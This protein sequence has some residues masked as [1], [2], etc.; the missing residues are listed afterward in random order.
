MSGGL[1]STEG[2]DF[3]QTLDLSRIKPYGD[4]MNDGKVQLS[5]T[6]PVP[7]GDE[8]IEAAKQLIKKMG[9]QNPQVV[10]FRELT[11]GFTFFNCYGSCE[12]TV[13]YSSIY[14]PKVESTKWD[15]AETDDFIRENIGRKIVVVGASTGTDA[16]TVGIDAIM[17]M[18]GFAG[19]YGLERYEMIEAYNLGSQVP[20][21]EFIAKGIELKADAL[22][23]SQTVTQKD[24]HIKNLIELVE[25]MEAEGLRDKMILACGGPRI[26][27]ELA[28][29]LGYDAGFGANTYADDVASFIAQ[30]FHKRMNNK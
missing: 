13:D 10:F 5:F 3:D 25:L 8:A 7:A 21:E 20:N 17:N 30:E 26:T 27:Y 6:L 19:H 2:R 29:E 22:L 16:H 11:E 14:V 23:V 1:Y 15:M 24:V 9:M 18:K 4:T 28:K 12:H